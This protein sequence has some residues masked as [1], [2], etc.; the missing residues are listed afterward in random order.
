LGQ[1]FENY[2]SSPKFLR[3]LF[4]DTKELAIFLP[5]SVLGYIFG[6]IFFTNSSGRPCPVCLLLE[7]AV[8]LLLKL[9]KI[10]RKLKTIP[11]ATPTPPQ[12]RAS[13]ARW[14]IYFQ[15]KEIPNCVNL[16]DFCNMSV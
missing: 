1:F 5:N 8:A 15:T 6:A 3:Y 16:R 11:S 9:A 4:H 10:N 14:Y 7:A 12:A 13:V 2:R